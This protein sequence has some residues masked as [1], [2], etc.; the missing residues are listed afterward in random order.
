LSFPFEAAVRFR[1]GVH[2]LYS[3]SGHPFPRISTTS[4]SS[5]MVEGGETS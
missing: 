4:Q 1:L 3:I 5:A 2:L